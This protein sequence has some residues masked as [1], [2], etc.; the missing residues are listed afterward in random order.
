MLGRMRLQLPVLLAWMAACA[1]SSRAADGAQPG[2]AAPPKARRDAHE[3]SPHRV[4]S[5]SPSSA[6]WELSPARSRPCWAFADAAVFELVCDRA[7]S[8]F[9]EEEAGWLEAIEADVGFEI[10]PDSPAYPGD[11]QPGTTLALITARGVVHRA[12]KGVSGQPSIRDDGNYGFRYTIRLG[13]SP[14]GPA[15]AIGDLDS[16]PTLLP[17]AMTRT[18]VG[19]LRREVEEAMLASR[20][21]EPPDP[22]YERA[23]RV[24]DVATWVDP[25]GASEATFIAVIDSLHP[26]AEETVS[27]GGLGYKVR[28]GS[29]TVWLLP[30]QS[31]VADVQIKHAVDLEGDGVHE[32]VIRVETEYSEDLLIARYAGQVFGMESIYHGGC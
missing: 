29:D 15:L 26:P 25:L 6:G 13:G 11:L 23:P 27:F 7:R 8:P 31:D 17:V 3:P 10:P 16:A 1:T 5:P 30:P 21:G 24:V 9:P 20:R 4:A 18:G 28:P 32:L 14:V 22:V 19:P 2:S 12:V